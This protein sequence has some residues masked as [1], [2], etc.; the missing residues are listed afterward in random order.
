MRALDRLRVEADRLE[1]VVGAGEVRGLLRPQCTHDGDR[2]AGPRGTAPERHPDR[3]EL[4]LAPAHADP[5]DQPPLRQHVQA[6]Y[7]FGDRQRIAQRKDEDA[8]AELDRAGLRG[9][10]GQRHERVVQVD[11]RPAGEFSVLGPRIAILHFHG[12][13]QMFGNPDRLETEPFRG[14]RH[15]GQGLGADRRAA[16]HTDQREF[17]RRL[18][19]VRPFLFER[20][21]AAAHAG[22]MHIRWTTDRIRRVP[23]SN[24]ARRMLS[25]G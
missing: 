14:L 22:A 16:A 13:G 9:D 24:A 20:A 3:I 6:G 4:L 7:G 15:F 8:R 19:I 21:E 10:E 23:S 18:S 1:V 11:A 2:L 17:H 25:L 5:E 12:D